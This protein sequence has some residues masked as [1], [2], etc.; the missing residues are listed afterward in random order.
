MSFE[1]LLSLTFVIAMITLE[2]I[3]YLVRRLSQWYA[4][5]KRQVASVPRD[6]RRA[7]APRHEPA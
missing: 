3:L 2:V 4:I 7:P 1:A 6:A 5:H